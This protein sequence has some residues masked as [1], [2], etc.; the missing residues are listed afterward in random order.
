VDEP[1]GM[2]GEAFKAI[3]WGKFGVTV[4]NFLDIFVE[5]QHNFY[6]FC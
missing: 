4:G 1:W 2:G 6:D 3:S 5:K